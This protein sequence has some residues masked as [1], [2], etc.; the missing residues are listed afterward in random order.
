M[1]PA[2]GPQNNRTAAQERGVFYT[3]PLVRGEGKKCGV[4]ARRRGVGGLRL[5]RSVSNVFPVFT[6]LLL[7]QLFIFAAI[8]KFLV[9]EFF[10]RGYVIVLQGIIHGSPVEWVVLLFFFFFGFFFGRVVLMN[11]FKPF[12]RHAWIFINPLAFFRT[13]ILIVLIGHRRFA[14]SFGHTFGAS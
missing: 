11:P 3:P 12:R 1:M 8:I 6:H 14:F 2:Q 9:S 13:D 5:A 4:A 7:G 10:N